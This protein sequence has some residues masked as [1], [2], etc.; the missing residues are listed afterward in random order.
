MQYAQRFKSHKASI[1]DLEAHVNDG[2]AA[3]VKPVH[4]LMLRAKQELFTQQS[5]HINQPFAAVKG[6]GLKIP[7]GWRGSQ[8]N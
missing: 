4:W 3:T 7:E 6:A 1:N 5:C 2:D 8:S